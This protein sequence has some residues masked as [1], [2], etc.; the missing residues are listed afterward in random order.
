[1]SRKRIENLMTIECGEELIAL[2]RVDRRYYLRCRSSRD[3]LTIARQFEIPPA[4][5][6]GLGGVMLVEGACN[7]WRD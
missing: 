6:K 5:L 1:M 7:E 2:D 3:P 4:A